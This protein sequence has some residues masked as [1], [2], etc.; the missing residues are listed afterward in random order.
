M[1]PPNGDFQYADLRLS[2]KIDFEDLVETIELH[3]KNDTSMSVDDILGVHPIPNR[4]WTQRVHIYCK[5]IE[6][7]QSLMQI[8]LDLYGKHIDLDEPGRG[9]HKV[10]IQNAPGHMPD[11]LIKAELDQYGTISQF[12]NETYKFKS[13]RKINWT[14]GKRVAW[15]KGIKDLPPIITVVWRSKPYELKIWYY[16]QT[17]RFCRF[18]REIVAKDHVC[19]QAP[20]KRCHHCSSDRHLRDEC[21]VMNG[22]SPPKCSKCDEP[23]H[24]ASDCTKVINPGQEDNAANDAKEQKDKQKG[25]VTTVTGE[26]VNR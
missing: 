14:N 6:S 19:D 1:P 4:N 20:V 15:M 8:G 7:K 3:I 21:P 5:D 2:T 12:R 17:D 16:G 11:F 24:E 18:C 23:G 22:Q 26:K 9:I 10:E 25:N 13:G